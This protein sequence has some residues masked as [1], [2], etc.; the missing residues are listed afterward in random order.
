MN[1]DVVSMLT[2]LRFKRLQN[3]ASGCNQVRKYRFR[4]YL[5]TKKQRP[6]VPYKGNT[7]CNC[8]YPAL[9]HSTLKVD[10]NDHNRWPEWSGM[11]GRDQ[12][13]SVAGIERNMQL[14]LETFFPVCFTKFLWASA[15]LFFF[16]QTEKVV[17]KHTM[18][19]KRGIFFRAGSAH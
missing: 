5:S 7:G 8:D 17:I 18:I 11:G 9:L 12:A 16:P 15:I 14:L 10:R 6:L 13:E 2:C 19:S 4:T 3:R 1:R